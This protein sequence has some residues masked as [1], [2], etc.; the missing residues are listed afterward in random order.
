MYSLA[1]PPV[2]E[3]VKTELEK[4]VRSF[5][6]LPDVFRNNHREFAAHSLALVQHHVLPARGSEIRAFSEIVDIHCYS[7][8]I[9]EFMG[10]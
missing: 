3:G 2:H 10:K 5:R 7:G 4:V 8:P 9:T 1:L 6:T